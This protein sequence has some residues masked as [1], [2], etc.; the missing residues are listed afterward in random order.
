M[1]IILAEEKYD[2]ILK[3]L[4]THNSLLPVL[5]EDVCEHIRTFL[6]TPPWTTCTP[7]G[8]IHMFLQPYNI[9]LDIKY[10]NIGPKNA[11]C[12]CPHRVSGT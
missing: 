9:S 1:G 3:H 7:C 11:T 6:M 2:F 4:S 5:P 8:V 12:T 10:L